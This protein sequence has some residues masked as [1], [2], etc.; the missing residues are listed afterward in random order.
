MEGRVEEGKGK[1]KRKQGR[2]GGI[3]CSCDFSLEKNPA[4]Y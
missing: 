2:K 4:T 3:V 1:R